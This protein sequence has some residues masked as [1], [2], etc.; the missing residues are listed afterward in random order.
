MHQSCIPIL[1]S[2]KHWG[3]K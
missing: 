2:C 3:N 1:T